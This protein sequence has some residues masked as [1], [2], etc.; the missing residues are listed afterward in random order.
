[1][2]ASLKGVEAQARRLAKKLGQPPGTAHLLRALVD[3]NPAAG[4][5]L[6][7]HGA[8]ESELIRA[9]MQLPEESATATQLALDRAARVA[10]TL[11]S[12]RVEP[13][14]LLSALARDS[15]SA[16]HR[17]LQALGVEP[18]QLAAEVEELV[19]GTKRRSR[20]ADEDASRVRATG[21]RRTT[22]VAAAAGGGSRTE[23]ASR[24]QAR[25]Q[26]PGAQQALASRIEQNLAL[27][28]RSG[29][30]E[31]PAELAPVEPAAAPASPAARSAGKSRAALPALPALPAP[32]LPDVLLDPKQFPLLT[33]LGRNLSAEARAGRLDPV[34]G[35]EQEVEQLLDVLARR[36][37]NN[38]VL[39]GQPGV[40]KTAVVE[41]LA[42][43]LASQPG[44][45]TI[46]IE[47]S[48]GRL[49]A[50]TGVRGAL[51]E[52]LQLLR[53]EVAR[54]AGRITLFI[55][56]IH[57]LIGAGEGADSLAN[58]LK[59]A[60]AR[61][62]LPCI[63]ATTEVEYAQHFERDAALSRRFT[64]IEVSEPTPEVAL[65][66]LRGVSIEY[67][68]HHAVAYTAEALSSAVELSVRYLPERR[69]PDK[70]IGVIDQAAARVARRGGSCVDRHDV[71]EVISEHAGVPTERLLMRDGEALLA[72]E[73]ELA[74]RVIGQAEATRAVA[75]ALRKSAAGFRGQRP[76]GS[77]LF[78]GPTGV[79]KTELARGVADALFP[80]MAL[81]R[82]D[83]AE[84]SEAHT[85]AR[86]LGAP[87]GYVGY[88]EGG[89]LTEPVRR[90][91]YQ[92]V[93]LD[94]VEKAHPDVLMA[95]LG[96]L[97]EGRLTDGRG[98]TVDFTN[99][100]VILTSNLGSDAIRQRPRIG[101]S[102][103]GVEGQREA[104]R[105]AALQAAR[106]ALPPELWNRLD[107]ALYFQ[108]L[109]RADVARI[110]ERMLD[111]LALT[112]A[113]QHAVELS[114]EPSV[115]ETLIACGGYDP[116][117]GARPMRRV[118]GR[119]VEA[120]LADAVLG[121]ELAEGD[122]VRLVGEGEE[123][124]LVREPARDAAE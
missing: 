62:E 101:F 82:L 17:V 54:G 41:G 52:R 98:R 8:G 22:S 39:V 66:L 69:L 78:L 9:L 12:A 67:E 68:K 50:G 93:L 46:L 95:L 37:A 19:G 16:A 55:D 15:R 112:V 123:L 63:G 116:E 30:P 84:F 36:R 114:F 28:R 109:E 120:R 70:A 60:L 58:E 73:S 124:R 79:G 51:S 76:L 88:E 1:M 118:V 72:L 122:R 85:V 14:H 86:L 102:G 35:R 89:Q 10:E 87:P 53:E 24:A 100:V 5:L 81:T 42:R 111:E 38:P 49:V 13:L 48:A 43:E 40:G 21:M 6:H 106:A 18:L 75:L 34:I 61:G 2:T 119:L 26:A 74:E 3:G 94:E 117:L 80:G 56:E 71:A 11:G 110:A 25:F 121:G 91:P 96:L 115:I 44:C 27:A 92:L 83:M 33:T 31:A 47:L 105:D 64:R 20:R 108:P 113:E 97:D 32:A 104:R 7:A 90:R 4:Q 57:T 65:E 77:F 107:E 59:A 99:S 103:G 45:R 23:T 29:R